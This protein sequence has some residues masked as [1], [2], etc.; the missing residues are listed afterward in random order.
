M[1]LPGGRNICA[2]LMKSFFFFC[3]ESSGSVHRFLLLWHSGLV[4][5]QHVGSQFPNQGSNPH[6]PALEGRF[7]TTGPPGSPLME[8]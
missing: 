3:A 6:P 5:P 7:F 8:S 4:A 1:F 2:V